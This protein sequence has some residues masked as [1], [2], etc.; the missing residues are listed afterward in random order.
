[1]DLMG[2]L[3]RKLVKIIM[4][5]FEILNNNKVQYE[6]DELRSIIRQER[7]YNIKQDFYRHF[8]YNTPQTMINILRGNH[9]RM[10]PR[11]AH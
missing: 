7:H 2:D 3:A 1:M 8:S 4:S 9:W 6:V 11:R 10:N 5:K